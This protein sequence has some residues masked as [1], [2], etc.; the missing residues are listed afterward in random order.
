MTRKILKRSNRNNVREV[1]FTCP[2][3]KFDHLIPYSR[4]ELGYDSTG[5]CWE[6]NGSEE[7]PTLTPSILVQSGPSEKREVCHSFVTSGNIQFLGDCT[8]ELANQTVPLNEIDED[9]IGFWS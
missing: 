3:C 4:P 5:P 8:H 6:F 7:S 2:G 1:V 9:L